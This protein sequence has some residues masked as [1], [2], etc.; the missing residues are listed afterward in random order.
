[1]FHHKSRRMHTATYK[2]MGTAA[3]AMVSYAGPD[4]KAVSPPAAVTLPW[5]QNVKAKIGTTLSLSALPAGAGGTVTSEIDVDGAARK[6]VSAPGAD[7]QTTAS[8]TL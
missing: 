5:T 2:V 7:G 8:A 1:M 3:Q 4:G 6:Q